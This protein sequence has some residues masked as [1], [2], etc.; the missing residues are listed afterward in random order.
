MARPLTVQVE[1]TAICSFG[2][3]G[4]G[5]DVV[6]FTFRKYLVDLGVG[7]YLEEGQNEM[8]ESGSCSNIQ[9]LYIFHFYLDLK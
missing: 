5:S 7:V 1:S 4:L 2:E 8:L 3:P 9:I 6:E